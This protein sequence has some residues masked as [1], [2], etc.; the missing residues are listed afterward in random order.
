MTRR[1]ALAVLVAGMM[2][3]PAQAHD[4][5]DHH[6]GKSHHRSFAVHGT[7]VSQALAANDDGTY[8][9]DVVIEAKHWNRHARHGADMES[10][11]E[12][13]TFTLDHAK[14]RFHVTDKTPANGKVDEDDLVAGDRVLLA[15]KSGHR[16]DKHFAGSRREGGSK[17]IRWAAFADPKTDDAKDSKR[18]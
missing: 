7:L 16:C 15:G 18:R 9:G 5:G 14:V 10:G 3:V 1:I 17:K 4:G 13:K 11:S 6:G 8:S 12:Q 2:A